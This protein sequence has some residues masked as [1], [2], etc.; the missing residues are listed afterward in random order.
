MKRLNLLLLLIQAE[1]ILCCI[2]DRVKQISYGRVSYI[3]LTG[4]EDECF[5]ACY[6]DKNCSAM[7]YYTISESCDFY[8]NGNKKTNCD[9][10]Y[11]CYILQRDE[12]DSACQRYV[13]F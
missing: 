9:G 7:G 11:H 4:S 1:C 8:S 2:F 12:V 10:E 5:A 3:S 6:A 13:K